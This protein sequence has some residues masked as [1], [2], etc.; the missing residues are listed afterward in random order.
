MSS[1]VV[2]YRVDADTVAQIE[3]E[4]VDGYRPAGV[5]D[6]V[7][8]VRESA[9]P[10]VAAAKVVLDEVRQA[11][12]DAVEVKFGIKVSGTANWVLAKAATEANFEVTMIW[13]PGPAGR[14]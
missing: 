1:E 7:A 6:I 4:P 3:I 12:P 2:R 10:A 5:G 11:A 8:T 14:G 9:A 13:K